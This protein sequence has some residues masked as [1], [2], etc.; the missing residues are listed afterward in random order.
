MAA[1]RRAPEQAEEGFDGV[2]DET[3]GPGLCAVAKDPQWVVGP[4]GGQEPRQHHAVA[5]GLSRADRVEESR[6]DD[7]QAAFPRIGQGQELV[8]QLRARVAPPA[9]VRRPDQQIV[10]LRQTGLRVFPIHLG[11]RGQQHGDRACAGGI[12]DREGLMQIRFQRVHGRVQ[13]QL[14][15]HGRGQ[16][17]DRFSRLRQVRQFTAARDF[18]LDDSQTCVRQH[19]PQVLPATG[20]EIIDH[21]HALAFGQQPLDQVRTDKPGAAGDQDVLAV[22]HWRV[23]SSNVVADTRRE[24][25]TVLKW[26]MRMTGTIVSWRQAKSN[27][28]SVLVSRPAPP[29]RRSGKPNGSGPR[30]GPAR[31]GMSRLE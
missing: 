18:R 15:P 4:G 3:E 9:D 5:A 28:R 22:A 6:D 21:H 24:T 31:R 1:R 29:E 13:H 2:A 17:V 23:S 8:H 26:L 10:L 16:V 7:R 20:R 11:R 14:H 30:P 12:Q 19:R 25:G 27:R